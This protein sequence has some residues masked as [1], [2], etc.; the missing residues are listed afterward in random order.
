MGAAKRNAALMRER[1]LEDVERFLHPA[2]DD[3]AMIVSEIKKLPVHQVFRCDDDVIQRMRM[4]PKECHQN[5]VSYADL[6]PEKKSKVVTGWM[7]HPRIYMLHSV[8]ERDGKLVCITPVLFG[9]VNP[10]QF[11]PDSELKI[12]VTDDNRR[13]FTRSGIEVTYGVRQDPDFVIKINTF[14]KERLLAGAS[15]RDVI[16]EADKFAKRLSVIA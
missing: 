16:A 8:I 5:C 13:R 14:V 12:T 15:P 11:I 4:K 9:D 7:V 10:F 1:L 3:E 6:D 2:T